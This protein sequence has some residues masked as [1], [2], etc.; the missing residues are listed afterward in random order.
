MA[1]WNEFR[2]APPR[3][4]ALLKSFPLAT[5]ED[6]GSFQKKDESKGLLVKGE[7]LRSS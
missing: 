3:V 7:R 5:S 6:S 1:V 2:C 4:T